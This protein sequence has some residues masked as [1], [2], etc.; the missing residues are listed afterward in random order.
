[1]TDPARA[2]RLWL[3]MAVATLWVVSVG[4]AA[5][6]HLPASR[7]QVLPTRPIARPTAK[8]RLSPRRLS[9]FTRGI[10]TVLARLIR[11]EPIPM[12]AFVPEMW[13]SS[14]LSMAHRYV[15]F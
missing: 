6:A 5:D 12:A 7:W 14:P 11:S 2:N 1:M 3:V 15:P 13:S 10:L 4:G 8:H 9:C